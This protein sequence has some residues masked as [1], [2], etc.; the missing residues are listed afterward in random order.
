MWKAGR[1]IFQ[2]RR[3]PFWTGDYLFNVAGIITPASSTKPIWSKLD[4]HLTVNAKGTMDGTK[5]AAELMIEQKHGHII[6]VSSLAG[7]AP[8]PASACTPRPKPLCA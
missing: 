6:N 3:Q 8:Y 1:A 2:T 7:I 4:R 5:L